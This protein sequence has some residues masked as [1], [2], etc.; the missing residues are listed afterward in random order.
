MDTSLFESLVQSLNEAIAISK[1][2]RYEMKSLAEAMRDVECNGQA[3]TAKLLAE[4]AQYIDGLEGDYANLKTERDALSAELA[5][6]REQEPIGYL[7][8]RVRGSPP[9]DFWEE[10]EFVLKEEV[11]QEDLDES[12][13]RDWVTELYESPKPPESIT[14]AELKLIMDMRAIK[15]PHEVKIFTRNE[16]TEYLAQ[17]VVP[18]WKDWPEDRGEHPQKGLGK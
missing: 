6:L 7:F 9:D 8:F 14:S 18:E 4:A 13:R 10:E 3:M 16:H 11:N 15:G 2:R 17:A 1:Q 12:K 5:A